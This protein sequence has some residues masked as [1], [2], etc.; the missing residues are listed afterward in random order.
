MSYSCISNAAQLNLGIEW[1]YILEFSIITRVQFIALEENILK[2][3]NAFYG[4]CIRLGWA[5]AREPGHDNII[6]TKGDIG[7]SIRQW[8]TLA[9]QDNNTVVQYFS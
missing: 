4:L 2:F 1:N 6:W 5:Y 7:I 9:K 3:W 8:I